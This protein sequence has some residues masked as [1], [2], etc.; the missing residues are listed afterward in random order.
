MKYKVAMLTH[1][2]LH[3]IRKMH[4]ADTGRRSRASQPTGVCRIRMH[5]ATRMFSLLSS[6]ARQILVRSP[7][8]ER[9]CVFRQSKRTSI[10]AKSLAMLKVLTI[11]SKQT[12][13]A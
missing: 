2:A 11:E 1:I 8:L 9:A 10:V 7:Y 6:S 3:W 4:D 12:I 13:E 5:F